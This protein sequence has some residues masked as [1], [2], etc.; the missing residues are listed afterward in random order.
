L[1][2]EQV[3]KNAFDFKRKSGKIKA[4]YE[5]NI[6]HIET[7]CIRNF[8]INIS[9]EMVDLNRK[10]KVY[11]NGK[12]FFNQKITYD[13]ECMLRNF[14]KNRDREQVWINYINIRIQHNN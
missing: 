9:P 14:D 3:D 4:K 13:Q 11:V 10:I 5:N 7:S 8:S 1:T 12:L 6:F 2:V